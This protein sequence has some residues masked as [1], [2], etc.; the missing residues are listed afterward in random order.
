M[1]IERLERNNKARYQKKHYEQLE[2]FYQN[3]RQ[4]IHIVGEYAKRLIEDYQEA[5]TFVDDYFVMDYEMFLLKYFKGRSKEISRNITPAKFKQLFGELSPA[6]LSIIN[7]QE[8]RYIVVAAGPGSGKT[9]LLTHKLASLYIMEDVKHEQMLMLTFSRAAATEFKKRL[10]ALIGNAANF[11]QIMTF[12]SYCFD[13][14]GKVGDMVKSD[15]I[16]EQTIGKIES[17]EFDISRLTKTVLV[18][19]EAQ[20]MSA[21]EYSLVRILIENNEGMRV[22]AV[23][24]DDQNI[25]EFRGSDSAHFESLLNAPGA[26]KYELLENYRSSANIVEFA[27]RFAEKLTHR[28]KTNPIMPVKRENGTI[29]ICKLASQNIVIPVVNAVIAEKDT[30]STGSTCIA[31]RTNEEAFNIAGLLTKNGISARLIQTNNDFNLYNLAEIRDFTDAVDNADDSYTI[32][33]EVWENAKSALNRKYEDSEDL[34][35][36]RRLIRDF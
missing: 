3:K 30:K 26:K 31:V 19:D 5:M 1:R 23:G 7:N 6:Q 29:S 8:S 28:I 35:G 21:A 32:N 11:I 25:Y 33:D 20:D 24:D 16:I 22:I 36:V 10:L 18:I 27:N 13:L 9:K 14:L 12:H 4:Q 15:T 34:P 2:E 17:G